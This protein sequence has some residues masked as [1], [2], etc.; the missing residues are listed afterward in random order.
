MSLLI[1]TAVNTVLDA[2]TKIRDTSSSHDRTSVIEVM[3]RH[4]GDIALYSGIATGAEI[5]VVPEIVFDMEDIVSRIARSRANGK[6][7]NLELNCEDY[8]S[9]IATYKDKVV[10]L[11]LDYLHLPLDLHDL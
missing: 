2:I 1:D 11:H 9:Y 10:E 5:I 6:F 4:C 3:G 7:S 8:A